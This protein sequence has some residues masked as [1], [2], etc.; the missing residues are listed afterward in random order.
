MKIGATIS[1]AY[2]LLLWERSLLFMP[3]YLFP[4]A[5]LA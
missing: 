4:V 1:K 3:D 5:F 2:E